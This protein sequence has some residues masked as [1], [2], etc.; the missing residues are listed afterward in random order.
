MVGRWRRGFL[1]WEPAV[2]LWAWRSNAKLHGAPADRRVYVLVLLTIIYTC[3]FIDRSILGVLAQPIKAELGLSD[4]QLGMLSGISFA[5]LYST[6]GLP[7][8]RL[9]ERHNRV[10][11]ISVSVA[12][13]SAFTALCGLASGFAQLFLARVGVGIGEAGCSPP[14][15]SLISDYFPPQNRATALAVYSLGLPF[16]MLFGALAGGWIAEA[17]GWRAAFAVVGLP[18]LALA[19]LARLT[20]PEPPRGRYDPAPASLETPPFSAVMRR[21]FGQPAFVSLIIGITLAAFALYGGGAFFV[22]FLLR[23]DFGLGLGEAATAYGLFVGVAAALGVALGG[24]LT[25]RAAVHGRRFYALIPGLGFLAA[26]PLFALAFLQADLMVLAGL[27][28]LPLVLQHLFFG[29]SYALTHGLVDA[30][31][32]ASATAILFLPATLLGLGFGPPF[33]GWLSDLFAARAWSAAN[34]G[35]F[36]EACAAMSGPT[37]GAASFAGVKWAIVT[38]LGVVYPLA[39]LFYLLSARA[40]RRSA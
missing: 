22:P 26:G 1:A 35:D 28:V 30:R 18:G 24:L 11:I 17:F 13:W 25:D 37:C 2:N 32:R 15:Q 19:V 23:G 8:A 20:I 39:G 36:R 38:T 12:V 6:L 4:T 33:V 27:A 16:G 34:P 3:N 10:T 29:P 31:M 9:A 21:L 14:A 40:L 5:I 7:I